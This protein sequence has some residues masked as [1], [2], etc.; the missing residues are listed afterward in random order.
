[1]ISKLDKIINKI[2]VNKYFIFTFIVIFIL[3]PQVK[4]LNLSLNI[5][6]TGLYA[7]NLYSIHYFNNL[8]GIFI[9]HFQPILLVLSKIHLLTDKFL[10]NFLILLQSLCLISPIFFY[11]SSDKLKLVYLISFPLWYINYNGFHTDVFVVP[12]LF[13]LLSLKNNYKYIFLFTLILIKEI[14][15]LL[16]ILYL[17]YEISLYSRKDNFIKILILILLSIVLIFI[18]QSLLINNDEIVYKELSKNFFN[19]D[20]IKYFFSLIS[21]ESFLTLKIFNKILISSLIFIPYL[22]LCFKYKIFYFLYLP[23]FLLYF[24]L[25][26]INY[27]K[28]YFHYSS[29]LIPLL[30]FLCGRTIINSNRRFVFFVLIN[31]IFTVNFFNPIFYIDKIKFAENYNYKNY[32]NFS[33]YSKLDHFLKD[34]NIPDTEA[35]TVSNNLLHYKI[36]NR[37]MILVIDYT[38]NITNSKTACVNLQGKK[39]DIREKRLCNIQAKFIILNKDD[40]NKYAKKINALD[41]YETIKENNDYIFIKSKNT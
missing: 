31:F 4:F 37:N 6:D 18:F 12:L 34:I 24:L 13:M 7:S 11:K 38:K 40:Y 22:F 23:I 35:I 36:I 9:G 5:F 25:D 2:I 41:E 32:L 19:V 29:F 1:M 27:L 8:N 30:F 16:A 14:Y 3:S 20:N 15:I 10:I 39:L 28:P 21:I 26:N 17:F 33:N